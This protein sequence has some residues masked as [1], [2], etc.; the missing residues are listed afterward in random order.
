MRNRPVSFHKKEELRTNCLLVR[1]KI[2]CLRNFAAWD[3]F[4]AVSADPTP[5]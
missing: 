4:F 3:K 2:W 1:G 5:V